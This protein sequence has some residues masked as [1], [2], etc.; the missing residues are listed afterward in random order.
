M[1]ELVGFDGDD[2][3]WRSQ[4][5]FDAAQA[6]FE[7]IMGAWLDLGDARLHERMLETER[8]NLALF[9]YG[10]KAMTLS[11]LETAI[12]LTDGRI[13]A[14]DLGRILDLGKAVLQHPVALLPGIAEAVAEVAER[15]PV[16]L[17][18]K[19]DLFHQERKVAQSGLAGL[20][21]RI[22]IVSEKDPAAYAR[23]LA[24]F[25]LDAA[26]FAMVGNSLRSDAEPVLALGGWAVH[27]PYHTTW[28]H[29]LAHGVEAGHPRLCLADG[30]AAIP[31]ALAELTARASTA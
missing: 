30:P 26:R 22:E 28:A 9:G 6:E 8:A 25:D 31:A 27:V 29:E 7:A 13:G 14:A 12:S 18:T 19:G 24:E 2:T 10:A 21:R 11:M 17:I 16:V 1:I 3:L 23:V 20:F 4:E 15:H 5:Y